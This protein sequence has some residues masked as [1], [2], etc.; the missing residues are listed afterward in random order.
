MFKLEFKPLKLKFSK[1]SQYPAPIRIGVF[2]FILLLLWVPFVVP[3]YWLVSDRNAASI[4]TLLILYAEF[5][6]LVRF[7]GLAVHRQANTF[8]HYGLELTQ[9]NGKELLAGL[10]VGTCSVLLLFSLESL[11]GWLVW[12][13]PDLSLVR[14]I[15]EGLLVSL[16]IGFA[17]ELLFRGWLLDELQRD[18]TPPVVLWVNAVVFAA[19]HLKLL[20]FPG[21]LLLGITLVWAKRACRGMQSGKRCDRL[22]L[23]IGLHAGLVWGNYVVEV[24]R[25]VNYTNRVPAWITG[26]ER[27]PLAGM[28]GLLLLSTLAIS[29]WQFARTRHQPK[30]LKI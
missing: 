26:I 2:V 3:I 18:Y 7:W 29:L 14:I 5:L 21:L 16:G 25:L 24:G 20:V 1:W 9:R 4:F 8:W 12:Q 10:G 30:N 17:E 11:A 27:N 15:L 28:L 22:G 19:I 23:S 6:V 13:S